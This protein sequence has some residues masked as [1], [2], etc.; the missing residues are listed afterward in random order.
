MCSDLSMTK[1]RSTVRQAAGGSTPVVLVVLVGSSVSVAS[2]VVVVVAPLPSLVL[3]GSPV[4]S[5]YVVEEGSV[6]TATLVAAAPV[7]DV[8]ASSPP[9]LGPVTS[10]SGS[11]TPGSGHAVSIRKSATSGVRS[12][13]PSLM[14]RERNSSPSW[15]QDRSSPGRRCII[16]ASASSEDPS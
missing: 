15:G 16:V 8:D 2:P 13:A 9:P 7:P 4:L 10:L 14:G 3:P 6:V 11:P 5:K 12:E 1:R